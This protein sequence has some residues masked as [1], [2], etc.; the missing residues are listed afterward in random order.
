[1]N[2]AG[3]P[4]DS[5]ARSD[6]P[7]TESAEFCSGCGSPLKPQTR[8]RNGECLRCA[9]GGARNS[10]DESVNDAA[11]QDKPEPETSGAKMRY[12]QFEI[13]LGPDGQPEE[14]G[15]GGA[16]TTYRA[17]DTVLQSLVALKIINRKTAGDPDARSRFLR[18]ARAAAKL[19]HPNVGS[20]FHYGEQ[21]GECYYAME[22]IQG[23]TLTERIRRQGVFTPKETLEVGIQ[24][25][26]ALAAAESF[27]LVHRDIKPSNL[28]L[29]A[30]PD[31]DKIGRI[32]VRVIDW[33]L[34]KSISTEDGLFGHD[35]TRDGF[36]GT[37]G[38][39]SPE[40]FERPRENRI[41]MRSDIYSLGVT[42]WYLLCGRTPLVG[43]TLETIHERQK[44]LPWDQLKNAKVPGSLIQVLL[45]ILAFD[46]AE[47][48]QSARELLDVLRRCQQRLDGAPGQAGR[49]QR[50]RWLIVVGLIALIGAGGGLWWWRGSK[51]RTNAT[52]ARPSLAVLPFE[53]LSPDQKQAYFAV[54]MWYEMRDS[55][56]SVAGLDVIGQDSTNSYGAGQPRDY[57]AIGRKL[58]VKHLLEGS[59]L[60]VD[61]RVTI[62]VRLVDT[63]HP[64]RRWESKAE[65]ALTDVFSLQNKL[66]RAVINRLQASLSREEDRNLSQPLTNDPVA[67]DLYLRSLAV[68]ETALRPLS[69]IEVVTQKVAL[70]KAAVEK[71]PN[72]SE[73]YCELVVNHLWLYEYR[74]RL[75]P[76][77]QAIDHRGLAETALAQAHRLQPDSAAVHLATAY[78]LYIASRDLDQAWAEA[79]LAE[80]SLPNNESVYQLMG[81][82]AYNRGRWQEAT[83]SYRKACA[84]DPNDWDLRTGLANYYRKL[85]RWADFDREWRLAKEAM[86]PEQRDAFE[87]TLTAESI[88]QTGDLA[89]LRKVLAGPRSASA[90]FAR[91]AFVT[92]FMLHLY[93][94]DADATAQ[95]LAKYTADP[96]HSGNHIY[97]RAWYEVRLDWLRGDNAQAEKDLAVARDWAA[98][99][100]TANPTDGWAL[101]M[102]ALFDAGLG[103]KEESVQEALR[104]VDLETHDSQYLDQGNLIRA[105]LAL[106]YTWTGKIDQALDV[107]ESAADKPGDYDIPSQPSYG[108]LLLNPCWDSLRSDPRF[109]TVLERFQRP[110]PGS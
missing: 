105:N 22:L 58:G 66:V 49:I 63:D 15:S 43:E 21:D 84:L 37:P 30:D 46:P 19:R 95:A 72:F 106:V 60:R 74:L 41:D 81:M 57:A 62:S 104:A 100:V 38:F 14:L 36:I 64:D 52:D 32:H 59:V 96:V 89:P 73:A 34:A 50:S 25:A 77:E 17:R 88:E 67:L 47:R 76:E 53:N 103:R 12:G 16:A 48:P 13:L 102:L 20:V 51:H 24:V 71:D 108:D 1:M 78:L 6:S 55:L 69:V 44:E 4:D 7:E 18:E 79:K 45:S 75:P 26:R 56:A 107:L 86:P 40:Q 42:L 28:M 61:Q 87:L 2:S 5:W 109:K 9:I 65:G 92:G 31:S 91:V 11:G 110:V 80:K 68:V 35:E 90:P 85:R 97:P 70:L 98:K 3:L 94:R 33:G 29:E 10:A 101:S 39:A 8:G 23:E 99:Q 93:E 27:G 82:V 83:Q 54:G